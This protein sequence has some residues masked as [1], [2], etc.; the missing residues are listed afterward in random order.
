MV[1][2]L[3]VTSEKCSIQFDHMRNKIEIIDHEIPIVNHPFPA[4]TDRHFAAI[5]EIWTNAK[6]AR[7]SI[8]WEIL[9]IEYTG[10]CQQ[11]GRGEIEEARWMNLHE[12]ILFRINHFVPRNRLETEGFKRDHSRRETNGLSSSIFGVHTSWAGTR[13]CLTLNTL[14]GS[15]LKIVAFHV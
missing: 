4:S 3:I 7:L 6:R 9:Q 13:M 15:Q 2:I 8:E 12:L 5:V 1:V 14:D 11:R 10:D